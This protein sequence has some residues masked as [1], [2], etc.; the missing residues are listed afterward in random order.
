VI[1]APTP[2][3]PHVWKWKDHERADLRAQLDA[4]YFHL[5]GISR[6]DAIYILSTFQATGSPDDPHSTASLILSYYN[7][8]AQA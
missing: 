1:S 2:I 6:D 3:P 8:Y 5:Y 4:A 7:Q